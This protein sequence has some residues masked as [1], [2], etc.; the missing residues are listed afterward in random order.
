MTF[1]QSPL[2]P[3]ERQAMERLRAQPDRAVFHLDCESVSREK[4]L[5]IIAEWKERLK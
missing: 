2:T 3:E 4:A 1:D 5:E